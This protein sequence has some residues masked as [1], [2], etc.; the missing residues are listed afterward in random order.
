MSIRDKDNLPLVTVFT[1]IYNTN[2]KFVI[3]AIES[4]RDNKYPNIQHIIID[5]CSPDPFSKNTV[6]EWVDK[7]QYPCE[8]YEHSENYGVCKSLNHVLELA[9]GKYIFGCSDDI[10]LPN[11]IFTEI[12]ILENLDAKYAATY[13]DAFLIDENSEPMY[14]LFIQ[15]YK[16]FKK[17]PEGDIYIELLKGNFL[18]MMSMLFKTQFIKEVGGFDESIGYEDFDLHLRLF[19]KYK[20]KLINEPLSKYRI[21]NDSLM[22]TYKNWN[23]DLLIIYSKHKENIIAKDKINELLRVLIVNSN[24]ISELKNNKIK[25]P[26]IFY[27]VKKFVL[28][29]N[30]RLQNFVLSFI[31][32]KDFQ[33]SYFRSIE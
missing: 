16:N 25:Y 14:G 32:E 26:F 9:K 27:F 4:I 28:L 22:K 20:I 15:Q 30:T 29:N 13:S 17:L 2:P 8:F 1:L 23:R 7:E 24:S 5:D 12:Q 10:I 11:K 19:K 3:E 21:H 31:Q 18:P 33:L 6:K